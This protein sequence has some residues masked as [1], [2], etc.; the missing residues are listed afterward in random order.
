MTPRVESLA[1][2]LAMAGIAAALFWFG[3]EVHAQESVVAA[4]SV[5]ASNA[6][7]LA[8]E[9]ANPVAALI[10]VPLQLNYDH[11]IGPA[12]GGK[13]WQL[14]IQPVVPISLSEDWNLI[15]RTIL[16]LVSQDEV[17]PGA[18]SQ[19]GIGDIVQSVFFSPKKPTE[20]GLI[21]GVGPVLL[22][23]TGSDDQLS[24]KKWGA[25]PTGVVLKQQ[26]PWTYGALANHIWSIGGS[27]SRDINSHLRAAL[28]QL[29]HADRL[30]VHAQHREHLRL[31]EPAMGRA[32]E[33]GGGQDHALRRPT[34]QPGRRRALLGRRPGQRPA[35]LGLTCDTDAAVPALTG[36]GRH[37]TFERLPRS[38]SRVAARHA[39]AGCANTVAVR[40]A[41][42]PSA[43]AGRLRTCAWTPR[44]CRAADDATR[45]FHAPVVSVMPGHDAG[46]SPADPTARRTGRAAPACCQTPG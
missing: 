11:D 4:K 29:R 22:L 45:A 5:A 37:D 34:G 21:W 39:A 14:N 27:G 19:S 24:A 43:R 23:P 3:T 35:R 38:R 25:G 36:G 18:G 40:T 28:R 7:D 1:T 41:G 17:F 10:S 8:K 13:R 15:S 42:L 16:P 26:G 44:A 20:G 12:R 30:V 2:A 33:R 32:G 6:A 31:G 9:L 46:Q